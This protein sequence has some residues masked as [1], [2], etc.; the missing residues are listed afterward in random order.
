MLKPSFA[1]LIALTGL[2]AATPA[3]AQ[4]ST[5]VRS[6]ATYEH[7]TALRQQSTTSVISTTTMVSA[8]SRRSGA[9]LMVVGVAGIVTGLIVD[10]PIV[11][12]AG[13]VVGGIGLYMYLDN[14]RSVR[15]GSQQSLPNFSS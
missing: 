3:Q 8:K 6:S 13:A 11:T 1:V 7:L 14:S 4:R 12:I 5:F 15:V 10:E 2:A 9:L